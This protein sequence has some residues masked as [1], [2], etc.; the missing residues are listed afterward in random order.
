MRLRSNAVEKKWDEHCC[1]LPSTIPTDV[2]DRQN[3]RSY[4]FVALLR[5]ATVPSVLVLAGVL[6]F[7]LSPSTTTS[8]MSLRLLSIPRH[9]SIVEDDGPPPD[10]MVHGS[11]SYYTPC[12][13]EFRKRAWAGFAKDTH[14]IRAFRSQGWY[15]NDRDEY[16]WDDKAAIATYR[17]LYKRKTQSNKDYAVGQPWQ[18]FSRIPGCSKK[19]GQKDSFQAGFRTLQKQYDATHNDGR[20]LIYFLPETYQLE[21]TKD[22]R[23]FEARILE[24]KK[25]GRNRPWVLKKA[26]IN[27]GR[28]IEM[29]PPD[30]EA[31]Y[32]ATARAKEDDDH[33]YIVQ[34]Y[35]CNELT[36]FNGKKFD[37]RFYWLVASVDPLIVL[38]HDGYARVAGAMYNESDWGSTGQHLTNHQF[39]KEMGQP[40]DEDV[41][42]DA[43]WRRVRE[44]YAANYERLSQLIVGDDPVRHVRNQIKEALSATVEAFKDSL[45]GKTEDTK[46][47]TENNFAFYGSDFIIDADLDVYYLE[48]QSSPGLGQS[49]DFRIDMFRSLFRPMVNIVEEIADKQE[50]DAKAN[51]LPIESLGDYEIIY[52]GDDWRYEFKGYKRR[53][54]KKG[55]QLSPKQMSDTLWSPN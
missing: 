35:V 32:T 26:D 3:R 29:L 36:W 34:S 43:L 7:V 45:T 19:M 42:W 2:E 9:T 40:T 20:D 25:L 28:G 14:V 4:R 55:C 23:K 47:T 24:E 10:L 8:S 18:R 48:A 46:V 22:R 52:A 5:C 15:A 49:L 54:D 44:H 37:L 38:Y 41:L 31:L 17:F 21:H 39:R 1:N 30:S 27:N 51:L 50:K 16:S 53:K 6:V 33:N 12:P 13:P 11:R